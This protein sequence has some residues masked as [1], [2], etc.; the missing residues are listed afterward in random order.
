MQ[1]LWKYRKERTRKAC[2]Q[3]RDGSELMLVRI[4][5]DGPHFG[6]I[7]EI[8]KGLGIAWE[9]QAVPKGPDVPGTLSVGSFLD[10]NG[11]YQFC[12]P[13]GNP[14]RNV[15]GIAWKHPLCLVNIHNPGNANTV[16]ICS[17]PGAGSGIVGAIVEHIFSRTAVP[18]R[19]EE[20][21]WMRYLRAFGADYICRATSFF[22]CIA[23]EIKCNGV[24]FAT[25]HE[26]MGSV[27]FMKEYFAASV[28]FN[29]K[30]YNYLYENVHKTHEALGVKIRAHLCN[31]GRVLLV[32]RNPL[33]AL[34]SIGK[35]IWPGGIDLLNCDAQFA[36]IARAQKRYYDSYAEVLRSGQVTSIRYE[37]L[38]SDWSGCVRAIVDNL[39]GDATLLDVAE[40]RERLLGKPVANVGH[41]WKPGGGK[42]KRY[43]SQWHYEQLE[44]CGYRD[45][46]DT[47]GYEFWAGDFDPKPV[48][49][50]E[51]LCS[52][53]ENVSLGLLA[54]LGCTPNDLHALAPEPFHEVNGFILSAMVQEDFETIAHRLRSPEAGLLLGSV[55]T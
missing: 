47:L 45:L 2:G 8:C 23:E 40:M 51:V 55:V 43:L 15:K 30:L 49:R 41:L 33:D 29:I 1:W 11:Q 39:G 21:E 34:V 24:N 38:F 52:T 16:F 25:F 19:V 53:N 10:G 13:V 9:H 36:S 44:A 54:N 17:Y 35:K 48:E 31:G 22:R 4:I 50:Y 12:P 7:A 42:Y 5:G 6:Q 32:I 37:E 26:G 28:L 14:A 46:A 3:M 20:D 27:A 18:A